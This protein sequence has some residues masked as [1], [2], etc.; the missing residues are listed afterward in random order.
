MDRRTKICVWIILA[1]LA[2]FLAYVILYWYLWGEAVNGKVVD[3]GGH[4]HYYLQSGVEV[5]RG[6]FLYSGLHSVSIW[7]TVAATMLAMLTLAKER[8]VVEMRRTLIRGRTFITILA[9]II[10][11]MSGVIT[12]WFALEFGRKLA[13]PTAPDE[14]GRSQQVRP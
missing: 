9:T 3:D 8:L 4:L 10:T 6:W 7:I 14:A 12:I 5:S 1:G 2:N 11:L 13:H